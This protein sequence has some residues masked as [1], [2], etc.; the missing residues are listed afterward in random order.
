MSVHKANTP[1]VCLFVVTHLRFQTPTHG[2]G[3]T[4]PLLSY[5]FYLVSLIITIYSW[6]RYVKVNKTDSHDTIINRAKIMVL[7]ATFNNISVISWR[8]VYWWRKHKYSE[9]TTNLPK[10]TNKF[11]QILLY[12]VQL[13]MSGMRTHVSDDYIDTK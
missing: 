3:V 8:L 10:V 12:W 13:A 5:P 7:N 6:F 11:D 2:L 4:G 9:K 1:V